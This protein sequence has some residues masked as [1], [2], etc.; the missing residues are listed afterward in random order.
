MPGINPNIFA[1]MNRGAMEQADDGGFEFDRDAGSDEGESGSGSEA[2]EARAAKKLA[3]EL[4]RG[5][6]R[7]V[8]EAAA[9]DTGDL[10]IDAI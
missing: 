5:A 10:D 7:N 6:A 3:E 8:K 4:K 2:E 9:A 1:P